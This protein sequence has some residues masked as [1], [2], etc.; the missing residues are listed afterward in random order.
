MNKYGNK[1]TVV[2]GISFDSKR[3]AKRYEELKLLEMG[4]V[5]SDLKL[6][7]KF[8]LVP[9]QRIDGR[10]VERELSYKADF[11]YIE[12]GKKV[13]EDSKGYRTDKYRIKRKLMLWVHGIRIKE[14]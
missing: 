8:I 13:V 14:V 3:E 9:S 4:G 6:Q 2:N 10:V 11:S 7:E 5:I 1:K 12:N